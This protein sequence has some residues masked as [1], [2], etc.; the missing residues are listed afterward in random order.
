MSSSPSSL[1]PRTLLAA[2]LMAAPLYSISASAQTTE[3]PADEAAQAAPI[4][5]AIP[6]GPLD[7]AL[8]QFAAAAGL[9]LSFEPAQTAGKTS[10]GLRGPYSV[11]DGFAALLTGSD[12]QAVNR[13]DGKYVLDTV[14]LLGGDAPMLPTVR[15][16]ETA[17]A[18]P[19]ELPKP[20]AGGQ[21]ARGGSLGILGSTDYM[22]T[23]FSTVSITEQTIRDTQARVIA[24]VLRLDA[25]FQNDN[26]NSGSG[27]FSFRGF[28][29]NNTDLGVNGL[30]GL[31]NFYDFGELAPFER[32]EVIK[33]P[34]ALLQGFVGGSTG[35]SI[36]QVTKRA[37]DAPITRIGFN[38]AT[39][40]D[41]YLGAS[42]DVGRRFGTDKAWGIRANL[43]H[44][45]GESFFGPDQTTSIGSLAVDYRG[46]RLRASLDYIKSQ[47]ESRGD[48]KGELYDISARQDPRRQPVQSVGYVKSPSDT[49]ISKIEYDI[50][51]NLQLLLSHGGS[52][53]DSFRASNS[54]A[55]QGAGQFL[56]RPRV[57]E[58]QVK[59]RFA[60]GR[61]LHQLT[62]GASQQDRKIAASFAFATPTLAPD[63]PIPRELLPIPPFSFRGEQTFS[64]LAFAD[65]V[66][67]WNDKLSVTLGLRNQNVKSEE[68]GVTL[69]DQ[70]A[71]TPAVGVVFRPSAQW[72]LYGNYIEGLRQGP[73][74]PSDPQIV[75]NPGEVFD[76]YQDTQREIGAKWDGGSVGATLALF[77]ISQQNGIIVSPASGEGPGRFAIDGEQRNRGLELTLFGEP[78]KGTRLLSGYTFIDAEL[79]RTQGGLSD[80]LE[81]IGTPEHVLVLNAEHDLKVLPGLTLTGGM[82][83]VSDARWAVSFI[84]TAM[85]RVDEYAVF[86]GGARYA[87]RLGGRATVFR[88]DVRNLADK[89]YFSGARPGLGLLTYGAPRMAYLGAEVNF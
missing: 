7:A 41:E 70:S 51:K 86:D 16:T 89:A 44:R 18:L 58:A 40:G 20:F 66:G 27:G 43:A 32:V 87:T 29:A 84:P 71:I 63:D 36:N 65:T 9:T 75:S 76:P 67:F 57:T 24:D 8:S 60:T 46:E 50:S 74:A 56:T 82:R 47:Y 48:F 53:G 37:T 3:E 12:L 28:F 2:C 1:G 33:G 55:E 77:E 72:S 81:P 80:G 30:Y 22:D 23:P 15:V 64:S 39:G 54:R 42:I 88:L 78:I 34:T 31:G 25:S 19:G 4:E 62:F 85:G 38:G 52:D 26:A 73:A 59:T 17:E 21:V 45:D 6:A 79:R 5:Y 61:V 11:A 49:L 10:P 68:N 69:Y 35:A 83:A 13:G 14:P